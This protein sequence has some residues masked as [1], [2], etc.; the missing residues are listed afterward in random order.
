MRV[1]VDGEL[2][3][4]FVRH[5]LDLLRQMLLVERALRQQFRTQ[6]QV[7]LLVLDLVEWQPLGDHRLQ[8]VQT[9]LAQHAETHH[10]GR[11]MFFVELDQ[12]GAHVDALRLGVF[13]QSLLVTHIELRIVVRLVTCLASDVDA[14]VRIGIVVQLELRLDRV[15]LLIHVRRIECGRD[16]EL[17]ESGMGE[18]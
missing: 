7:D 8:L 1:E 5:D 3:G 14:L 2:V 9:R 11:V 16:E 17:H 13:L 6:L 10:V 15:Q 4:L 18:G 12:F